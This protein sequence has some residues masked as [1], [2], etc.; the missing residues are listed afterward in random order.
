MPQLDFSN[1][2]IIAQIVWLLIIFGALYYIMAAYALPRVESVL[3]ERRA[4]IQG[5]LDAAQAMQ[6]QA[7]AAIATYREAAAR[8]RAESQAAIA[9]ALAAAQDEAQSRADAL[10][11]RLAR[12]IDE[13][14]ARI[15]AARDNAMGALRQVAAETTGALVMKLT[16]RAEPDR[17]VAAVDAALAARTG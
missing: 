9:T 3:E 12:Q 4:R 14:D 6:T 13:A 15:Q 10:A 17:V 2:L 11:A 7:E 8:A 16:G 1:P 5:D